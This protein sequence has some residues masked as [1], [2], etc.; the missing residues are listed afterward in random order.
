MNR[1]GPSRAI[2]LVIT[3]RAASDYSEPSKVIC[4]VICI[5]DLPGLEKIPQPARA[6]SWSKAIFEELQEH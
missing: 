3:S 6:H 1:I 2:S 4:G 5:L